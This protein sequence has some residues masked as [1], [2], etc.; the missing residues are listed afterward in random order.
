M[1]Q[2]PGK[3][4]FC[5]TFCASVSVKSSEL[6]GTH[7]LTFPCNR[8]FVLF[9]ADLEK[10][11]FIAGKTC[12]TWL[13]LAKMLKVPGNL[14]I[15]SD[16][17][18]KAPVLTSYNL[19]VEAWH[20]VPGICYLGDKPH[21]PNLSDLAEC[22]ILC[23]SWLQSPGKVYCREVN[24]WVTLVELRGPILSAQAG[25]QLSIYCIKALCGRNSPHLASVNSAYKI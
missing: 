5:A 9:G 17:L 23:T 11:S 3:T 1:S 13:T 7:L 12:Q 21:S 16:Y 2:K 8:N 20:S 4:Q 22:V 25:H 10:F 6:I 24:I 18:L 19:R 14:L 15:I